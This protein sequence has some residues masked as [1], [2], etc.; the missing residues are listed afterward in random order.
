MLNC[1]R[2]LRSLLNNQYL[3]PSGL[4]PVMKLLPKYTAELKKKPHW[5]QTRKATNPLY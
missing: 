5:L 2:L 3:L 1:A 4:K